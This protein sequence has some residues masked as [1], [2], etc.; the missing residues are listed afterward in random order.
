M[1]RKKTRR[2]QVR[3]FATT[4]R[5]TK[6][7]RYAVHGLIVKD[8]LLPSGK[9]KWRLECVLC[10]REYNRRYFHRRVS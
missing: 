1:P 8:G 7:H 5:C 3:H 6:G 9:Q 4:K 2:P 10:R